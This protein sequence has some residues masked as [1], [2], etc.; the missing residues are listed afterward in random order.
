ME[1]WFI[2]G[3]VLK[4]FERPKMGRPKKTAEQPKAKKAAKKRA[5]KPVSDFEKNQARG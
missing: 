5:K 2:P 3:D 4:D 1:I